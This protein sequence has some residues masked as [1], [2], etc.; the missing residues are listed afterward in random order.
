[1]I[2]PRLNLVSSLYPHFMS[3][4]QGQIRVLITTD[5]AARGL[6]IPQVDLVILTS[7]PQDWESYVHRSGRTGRAG[8][9]GVAI[10]MFTDDQSKQLKLV[11]QNANIHFSNI[12]GVPSNAPEE[13]QRQIRRQMIN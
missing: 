7:P 13:R 10:C 4:R 3:F 6:D 12:S 8:R 1:M 2:F 5:V 11:Q 9:Q